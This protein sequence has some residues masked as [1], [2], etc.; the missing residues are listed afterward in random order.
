MAGIL[1]PVIIVPFA[2]GIKGSQKPE[3]ATTAVYLAHQRI[4]ELMKYRYCD[5]T[6]NPMALTPYASITGF[7]NYQWQWSIYYVDNNFQNEDLVTDRGY[8]RILVRVRDPDGSTYEMFSVVT[9]W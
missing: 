5:A 7:S 6:L 2:T 9:R 3:I 4:E 8:K 1:L